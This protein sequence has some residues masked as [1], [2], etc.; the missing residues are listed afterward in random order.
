[1]RNSPESAMYVTT[2]LGQPYS[3][4]NSRRMVVNHGRLRS[5]KSKKALQY[6]DSFAIQCRTR[7][8]LFEGDLV[9]GMRIYYGSLKPDL[10]ESLILDAMQGS[11]YLNDRQVKA[12]FILHDLD[13]ENPRSIIVVAPLDMVTDVVSYFHD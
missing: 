2:I 7:T 4:A 8:P 11:V 9:V 5:I 1:M 3:K 12:K 10:D 13:R 6:L